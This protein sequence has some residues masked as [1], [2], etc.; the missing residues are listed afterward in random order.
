VIIANKTKGNGD[1]ELV[2]NAMTDIGGYLVFE[3]KESRA[4]PNIYIEKKSIQNM[5]KDNPL[6]KYSY[7]KVNKQF[8]SLVDY[9]IK[10]N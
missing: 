10:V 1:I 2:E 6:L 3:I 7:R 8:D 9:L 5:M 4:L